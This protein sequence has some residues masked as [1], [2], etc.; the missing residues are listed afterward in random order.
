MKILHLRNYS[1]NKDGETIL[2]SRGGLTIAYIQ[3]PNTIEWSY[4]LCNEEDVF[5]RKR[6]RH[7]ATGRFLSKKWNNIFSDF[8]DYESFLTMLATHDKDTLQKMF[9]LISNPDHF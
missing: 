8:H 7:I 1:L 4:A 5:C 9:P 6:G 3:H 2:D